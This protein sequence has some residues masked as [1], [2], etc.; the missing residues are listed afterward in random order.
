MGNCPR[1]LLAKKPA[2]KTNA[3]QLMIILLVARKEGKLLIVRYSVELRIEKLERRLA[4]AKS[5]K[6]TVTQHDSES[7]AAHSDHS[8]PVNSTAATVDAD[9]R[10]SLAAIR[11]A[12]NRKA[13]KDRE[14]ADVNDIVS[15]FGFL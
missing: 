4:Y 13:A 11:A 14:A 6:A 10:D 5:F 9:R 8:T 1:V 3:R 7:S 15:D 2:V 12:V